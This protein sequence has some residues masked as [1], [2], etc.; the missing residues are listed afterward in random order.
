MFRDGFHQDAVHG[1]V[2]PYRPNSL[3]CGNPSQADD[4][5]GAFIDIP[6]PVAGD[7]V[8]E[9]SAGFGDHFSQVTL[10]VR[11]LTEV[12]RQHLTLA[13]TFELGK[14]FE[15]SVRLRQLQCLANIDADLCADVARGLGLPAR[16][17]L[18]PGRGRAQPCRVAVAR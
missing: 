16:S 6:T 13:Y 12:E 1:G 9:L 11:S 17:R 2:A 3:D 5:S 4:A 8:R 18:C 10:F 15:E 7:K 14:C